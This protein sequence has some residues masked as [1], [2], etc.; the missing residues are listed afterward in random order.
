MSHDR[1]GNKTKTHLPIAS[2]LHRLVLVPGVGKVSGLDER[3]L[4][5]AG[6]RELN[7]HQLLGSTLYHI[8]RFFV[9]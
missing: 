8:I 6:G 2:D 9:V 4:P 5:P 3:K 1:T 7:D